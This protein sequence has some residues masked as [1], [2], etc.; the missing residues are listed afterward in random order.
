LPTIR[1]RC[2]SLAFARLNDDVMASVLA[3]KAPEL[4]D[5][6]RAVVIAVA[7]GA[8]GAALSVI[9][10]DVPGIDAALREIATTGDPY[11]VLRLELAGKLALKA[12]LPRYEAFLRRAPAFIASQARSRSGPALA[13]AVEAWEKTRQLADVAISQSLPAESVVFEIAGRVATLAPRDAS[14]KA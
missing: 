12:A 6:T 11:N 2:R 1:S 8:P 7:G 14:A 9:E 13:T 4:D 5:M 3:E 10:A